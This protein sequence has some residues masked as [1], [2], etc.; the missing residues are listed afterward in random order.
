[1]KKQTKEALAERAAT[2]SRRRVFTSSFYRGNKANFVIAVILNILTS[3]TTLVVA[4]LLQV[5]FDLITG[6]TAGELVRIAVLTVALLASDFLLDFGKIR[7][8]NSFTKRAMQQYKNAAC[9]LIMKKSITGFNAEPTANYISAFTNDIKVVE[10]DYLRS[11]FSAIVYTIWFAGS[12][13]MML[14][15]SAKL[16]VVVMAM[17][18]LPIIVSMLFGGSMTKREKAVSERNSVFVNTVKDMLSGFTVVKSF[19]AEKEVSGLFESE[20]NRLEGIKCSRNNLNNA[21][22]LISNFSGSLVQF[23]VMLFGAYLALRGEITAGVV[24]AFVQLMNYVINPI[25][26][27]PSLIVRRKAA[28][29][30]IDKLAAACENNAQQQGLETVTDIGGGIAVKDVTYAYEPGNPVLSSVNAKFETGK[31][32]AIVGGSGSG[33]STLLNLMLGSSRDYEGE[34]WVDGKEMRSISAES[35]Y[36]MLSIVQQ[37]VFMFDST[38]DD[39]I[40][41]FKDFP[42]EQVQSAIDRAGLRELIQSRGAD[43]YCGENGCGL[44]GGERQRISI[45]RCLLRK[46]P[47]LLMDEA[48]SA[49]DTATAHEVT[50]AILDIEGLT[51]IIVTHRL[52]QDL[53]E[54]YDE[55]LVLN[56]GVVAERGSFSEL[57]QNKGYFYSLYNVLQ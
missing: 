27:L 44:S 14:W 21:I 11:I 24:I 46:T 22:Q 20:N 5:V 51:R 40:T 23:A 41:L 35:L 30:L 8:K 53:L 45:A 47:V 54:R 31:S 29:G 15:Y 9:G 1:M 16:T 37:N 56:S 36:D 10:D 43:Y 32:Y 12:L 33:K 2:L 38:I 52:E 39:N 19:K 49:L 48:T 7:S 18:V 25:S 4:Y 42:A 13:S 50:S 26:E 34:I 28:A 57:M 17:C 55:I 3:V 6:G